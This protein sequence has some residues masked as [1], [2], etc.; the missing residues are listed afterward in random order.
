MD[1]DLSNR[2]GDVPERFVPDAMRGELVEAE[3]LARYWWVAALAKDRTV[4][5]AGCGVGYGTNILA[6]AGASCAFGVDIAEAVIS[7]ATPTAADGALFQVADIHQL[8]FESSTFDLVVC[9]EV[10]EHVEEWPRA[11]DELVRVL[12][13]A[14][15][16]AMSSPNPDAYVPGNPH[17]VHEF[18]PEE[19]RAVLANRLRHVQLWY[20]HDWI[21]SALMDESAI[22]SNEL[23]AIDRTELAKVAAAAPA[24][25]PYAVALASHEPLPAIANRAVA[26]GLAEARRWLELFDAQQQTLFEQRALTD[27]QRDLH[28]E[29]GQLHEQLRRSEE[30]VARAREAE[31]EDVAR[32]RDAEAEAVRARQVLELRIAEL[33]AR[34]ERADR[35]MRAMQASASWR[36]TA[37]LRSLKRFAR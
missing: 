13:P 6:E 17:H 21:A 12:R 9:F 19:L 23:E 32:A 1:L 33:T 10:I 7:A 4:L 22:G 28:A 24:A 8:P 37:P 15:V 18:R 2:V 5:D 25:A 31:A 11:I 14:G 26:T 30:E 3:H 20:Q 16:L 27:A 35:V 29:L 34:L 36:V